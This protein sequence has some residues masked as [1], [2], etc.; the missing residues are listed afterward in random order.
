MMRSQ[1]QSPAVQRD[2][3]LG[4]VDGKKRA[5][6]TERQKEENELA[7]FRARDRSKS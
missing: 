2:T 7:S 6:Q 5:F 4:D 3:E 1:L